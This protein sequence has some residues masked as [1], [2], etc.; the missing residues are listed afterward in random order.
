MKIRSVALCCALAL[1]A[2]A[3][4]SRLSDEE[5][6][7]G[8]GVGGGAPTGEAAAPSA[9]EGDGAPMIGTLEIPC[10]EG[11]AAPGEPP[12]DTEGVTAE[13]VEIAVISDKAGQVKVPTA[14]IEESM[15]AFV[16]WC[17]GQGGVNGRQLSLLKIDSKL[18]NHLEATR[19]ACNA[20]VFAIVGSGSVTDNAG[21]QEMVDCGLVEVP[22]YTATAAKGLSDN[23]VAPVPNPSNTFPNGQAA[24]VAER[25]PEAIKKAAVL[26]PDIET[27][28]VQVER[29]VRAYEDL[30]FE[31]VY[32]KKT[33]ALQESYATEA[34]EMKRL[35]VEWVTM[36]SPVSE[37]VKLLDDM[38]TQSFEPEVVDLGQQYYDPELLATSA[39]EG[40][41]VQL[42]TVPFEEV[43]QS[44]ALQTYLEAYEAL[45]A[46]VQPTSLGVQAFSA[47][48]LFATALRALGDDITREG[49][50][51]EL[52]TITE[53]DGGG[54]HFPANPGENLGSACFMYMEVR[55]G[56]FERL[57][58]EEPTT[59][60]C[61]ESY[62]FDLQDDFGGGATAGG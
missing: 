46:S 42:N 49:L 32:R 60:D 57:W 4:G 52:R 35:G 55:D 43:D 8:G 20:G 13:T 30:G 61:D 2:T 34:A 6:A 18:F 41:I 50:L 38:R 3:C 24:W 31:F 12:A 44:P 54:L 9:P 62:R 29:M 25:H 27:S 59:W 10:G 45:D 40:A 48:L 58:P 16:D 56:A 51:D 17:N 33:G 26:A 36:V 7:T 22:G 5:L 28:N 47:G 53:W 14:S 39:S 37:T 1:V 11:D 21:A 23:L 19:E 15:Q